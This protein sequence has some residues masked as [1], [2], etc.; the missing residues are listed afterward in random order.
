MYNVL[1]LDT[2]T[3]THTH[4]HTYIHIYQ[5]SLLQ[6]EESMILVKCKLLRE[7]Y[8]RFY[9]ILFKSH[10]KEREKNSIVV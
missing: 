3:H 4:T 10:L 2:H 8:E 1:S 6:P 7:V 5:L 9:N